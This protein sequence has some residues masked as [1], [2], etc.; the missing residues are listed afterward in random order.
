MLDEERESCGSLGETKIMIVRPPQF[1]ERARSSRAGP[2]LVLCFMGAGMLRVL[3]KHTLSSSIREGS[4]MG[5]IKQS[6][7]RSWK[8][9]STG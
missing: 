1:Q 4:W 7:S 8:N 9:K 2:V 5:A 3:S 6:S